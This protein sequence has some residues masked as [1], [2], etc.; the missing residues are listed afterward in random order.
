MNVD[1]FI[2]DFI[3]EFTSHQDCY[4]DIIDLL[5][6]TLDDIVINNTIDENKKLITDFIGDI[7]IAIQLYKT[8]LD[9]IDT[10]YSSISLFYERL[11]FI[12][13]FAT[14]YPKI[15][16]SMKNFTSNSYLDEDQ[17]IQDFV[18]EY[19]TYKDCYCDIIDLLDV[20]LDDYVSNNSLFLNK[21]IIL[22]NCGNIE[23]AIN[24]YIK[25]LGNIKY[26]TLEEFYSKLTFAVLFVKLYPEIIK[27]L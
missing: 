1:S 27:L 21:Q 24:L 18:N 16:N 10:I 8:H 23:N 3:I 7:Y 19:S 6:V 15:L 20:A 2:K 26:T 22:D 4:D 17:F 11:A 13:L 25:N 9:D 14:L 5:D 12:S